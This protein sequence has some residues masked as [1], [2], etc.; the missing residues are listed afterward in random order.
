MTPRG[1]EALSERQLQV[2]LQTVLTAIDRAVLR[3][4]DLVDAS[5]DDGELVEAH[6]GDVEACGAALARVM[7]LA[8][9]VY[10]DDGRRTG[11][12]M[13]SVGHALHGLA[14][15]PLPPRGTGDVD[16]LARVIALAVEGA[17]GTEARRAIWRLLTLVGVSSAP[18]YGIDRERIVE[19]GTPGQPVGKL[20]RR[21]ADQTWAELV[22]AHGP[23]TCLAALVDE[24]GS[25]RVEEI[26]SV[27]ERLD[28]AA[29]TKLRRLG[30][31]NPS[32]G[33]ASLVDH[34]EGWNGPS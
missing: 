25:R 18:P 28:L 13:V 8:H 31:A 22:L 24:G 32:A 1:L 10:M 5:T 7:A 19:E 15:Y 30:T 14:L 29:A 33:V 34:E 23:L 16:R 21:R 4:D 12:L 27:L 11:A 9:D 20:V 6:A 3:L 26:A 2:R 17:D